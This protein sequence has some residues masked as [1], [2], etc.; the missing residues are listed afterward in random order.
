MITIYGEVN[1]EEVEQEIER[2]WIE[3]KFNYYGMGE[4]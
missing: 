1:L 4:E 2:L 3:N